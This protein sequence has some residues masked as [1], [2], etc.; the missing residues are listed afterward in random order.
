MSAPLAGVRVVELAGQGPAPFGCMLLADLGAE[1]ITVQR[2]GGSSP[3]AGAHG[4]GR[5]LLEADLK[6]PAGIAAVLDLVA[7]ADVRVEAFRPGVAERLGVGPKDCASRNPGL[8]YARMTGWGQDGPLAQS[9]GHDINYLALSG[10]LA[11]IGSRGGPPVPPLNLVADYGAGGPMLALGVA[12]ALV[13]RARTGEGGVLDVAM[14]DGL[15][16][17]LAPFHAAAAQGAWSAGRGEN[18]LDGGAPFYGVYETAD[19]RHMAVGAIEAPF[20]AELLDVL[21]IGPEELGR[22][23]DRAAWPAARERVAA[24]FASRSRD[25]WTAAF[26]GTDACVTP[27]LDLAEARQHRHARARGAF[28]DRDGVPHP[29]PVPRWVGEAR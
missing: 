20:Y 18:F 4:R 26:E 5:H 22:Q 10:G 29:A 6:E 16:A 8:V 23:H 17:M 24:A 9:A 2:P 1:V 21:E 15:G 7:S 19:G 25:E 14:V 3:G 13:Q 11:L 27:V 28:T 12:A